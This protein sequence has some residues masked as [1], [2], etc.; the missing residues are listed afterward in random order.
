MTVT[1][2]Q[3]VGNTD[4]SSTVGVTIQIEDMNDNPPIFNQSRYDATLV[5][6]VAVGTDI[7]TV[8]ALDLDTGVNAHIDYSLVGTEDFEIVTQN[9]SSVFEGVIRIKRPLDYDRKEGAFYKFTVVAKD[10]GTPPRS[11]SSSVQVTVT[12]INDEAPE[13]TIP[14]GVEYRVLENAA[15]NHVITQIQATDKDGDVVT[16]SFRSGSQ[17][18]G[19]FEIARQT[20]LIKLTQTI[21]PADDRFM[22]VILARDD[23]SCCGGGTT[24]SSSVTIYVQVNGVNT[25]KPTFTSCSSYSP[26]IAEHSAVGTTVQTVSATDG[27]RGPN[28]VVTYTITTDPAGIFTINSTTGDI[29]VAVNTI[30]REQYPFSQVTVK[31]KDGGIPSLEGWCTFRV[32]IDDINDHAPVF[33]RAK[34]VANITVEHPITSNFVAIRA[35]D[36]DVG[37][38]GIITYSLLS[39]GD[40]KF[41]ILP[42]NGFIYLT[43]LLTQADQNGQ[44]VLT[45]MAKDGGNPAL[46]STCVVEV[47]V[48]PGSTKP[49]TWDRDDYS[50]QTYSIDEGVTYGTPVIENMSCQSNIADTRV[51]FQLDSANT[52]LF[53]IESPPGNGNMV[54]LYARDGLDYL[55][56]PLHEVRIRCVNYGSVVLTTAVN[57]KVQLIDIN[58][59]GP[60]F[61]G[62]INDNG[63]YSAEVQENKPSG[64]IVATIDARD[65]DST[66]PFNEL[67]FSV[68]EGS[69]NFTIETG[70]QP[71]TAIIRTKRPFDRETLNLHFVKVKAEDGA[72]STLPNVRPRHNSAI[73][74][75]EVTITDVNDNPPFFNHTLYNISV[76][77]CYYINEPILPAVSV[78]DPDDSDRG[79]HTYRITSGNGNPETFGVRDGQGNLFL[80]RKL[81]FENGDKSFNLRLEAND[82]NFT[83][84]TEVAVTVLDVNDNIPVF[85]QSQYSF[86]DITENDNNVPRQILT[87]TA[88][89]ADVDRPNEIRYHLE[90]NPAVIDHFTINP[91]SGAVSVTRSLDRDQPNGF[92][93]YQFTVAATDER[94]NPNTGYASVSVRPQDMND[95]APRFITDPLEGSVL[96]HSP[97]ATSVVLVLA[98]DYD[99]GENGTVTYEISNIADGA[100]FLKPDFFTIDRTSGLVQTNTEPDTLDRETQ[101]TYR[102]T[103]I[104]RDQGS[105]PLDTTGTLTI[106]LTDKNDQ[107]PIFQQRIYRT[108]MSEKLESGEV[109]RVVAT[110]A[111]IGENAQISYTLTKDAD[112]VHF[113][114]VDENN[115]GSIRVYTPV[116]YENDQQRRFNLTVTAS[117]KDGQEDVC[118]VEIEVV[119]FNDNTPQ[120]TPSTATTN[121]SEDA[122][123]GK[124]LYTFSASDLDSGINQ[125]FEFSIRRESDPMHQFFIDPTSGEVKTGQTPLDRET[126][127]RHQIII[128]AI[129]KGN[130]PLTGT[131][132]LVVI[133]DDVND[134]YPTFRQDYHPH[135]LEEEDNVN[136][137]VQEILAKDPDAPP[138]GPPFGFSLT[139]CP[140]GTCPCDVKLTCEDTFQ[141]RFNPASDGG[142]GTATISTSSRFNREQQKYYYI[143][144][145][146]WDMRGSDS[147]EAQT[148]TNT[149]TVTI[150]DINDNDM[151]P[152]T[153]DIFVYNYEGMF[154]P[155]AIG[156]V[157]VEDQDDWDLPDKTFTFAGPA[158]MEK[159]FTVDSDTGM[160]TMQKGVPSN[161]AT[162]PYRFTVTVYDKQFDS[163]VTSTVSVVIHDL[164]EEA[165]R[166]SGAVR[167]KDT[168]AEQFIKVPS[169]PSAGST[170]R[171]QYEEL[172]VLLAEKL[173]TDPANVEIIS[174]QDVEGGFTDV[175]YSA[176]GSPYYPPSQ[177]DSLVVLNKAE[178]ESKLGVEIEEVPIDTCAQEVFEGGCYN[179][180]NITGQPAMVNANGTSFVGVEVFIQAMEGCRALQ[181]P[182]PN[183]CSGD[184]CYHGGTCKKDDFGVLSCQCPPDFDGPRCQQLRHSFDGSSYALYASLEQ[185]ED[186]ETSIEFITTQADGLLL[187][188]GPLVAPTGQQPTDFIALELLGGQPRLSIDHGSG[189]AT[190]TLN[191]RDLSNNQVITSLADGKWHKIDIIRKGKFVEM[192]V[193]DCAMVAGSGSE[194]VAPDISPCRVNSTTGGENRFLN[195]ANLL[196][197]GGRSSGFPTSV[198][199][200]GFNGCIKNLVH[201][202]KY[203]DLHYKTTPG[204]PSGQNGCPRED[205]ICGTTCGTNGVCTASFTPQQATC[206]CK[207]G[208]RGSG[209]GTAT[210]VRDLKVSSYLQWTLKS[211]STTPG[212]QLEVQ[213]MYRTWDRDGVLF[214]TSSQGNT[215]SVILELKDGH[216]QAVYNLGDG[217]RMLLLNQTDASNG[218]WHVARFRR[219]MHLA[220]LTLDDGEGR[221][222]ASNRVGLDENIYMTLDTSS[223]LYAGAIVTNPQ[224]A[225][226]IDRDLTDTCVQDV[227]LNKEWMPMKA[228][229]NSQSTIANH[230]NE[231]NVNDGCPDPNGC[232]PPPVPP[233]P[234]GQECVNLWGRHKC[235]CAPGY[236]PDDNSDSCISDCV[237]NPCFQNAACQL[238]NGTVVCDCA[239]FIPWQG[240]FCNIYPTEGDNDPV[241]G[242]AGGTIAAIVVAIVVI[243]LLVL[244]AF[245]LVTWY[246]RKG[247]NDGDKFFVDDDADYDIR[248]NV[249]YYDE[250]GAGEEDQNAFDLAK[251]PNPVGET[252]KPPGDMP[253]RS[254]LPLGRSAVPD[255]RP[256]VGNVL[257]DRMGDADEDPEAPPYDTL[258]A[259]DDEGNGSTAGSL[260]SLGSSSSDTSQD[261]DY[262]NQWGPKFAKLAD[263]YGAGQDPE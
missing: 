81:D 117:D 28:G 170:A 10:R 33:D 59:K 83:A 18:D 126:D 127:A 237:P 140:G 63:R 121:V 166:N 130:P 165:V 98:D 54:T 254:A 149:L 113:T 108:L 111:D 44:F 154:G 122:P 106:T 120:I 116:D 11:A 34:Y 160:V 40:G 152:G 144:I 180:M 50:S 24:L 115:E 82:G 128:Q 137:I 206:V 119:D 167:L 238:D 176:H 204:V 3:R 5:E 231:K 77:E 207:P 179:Y 174:V 141:F 158:W 30:D 8:K 175:R 146:M 76:S 104:L 201:N 148:G 13:F 124:L 262:L 31:G 191:G 90:G 2:T 243:V 232:V 162:N 96:E 39:D 132:T 61:Q 20:G 214:T 48:K 192:M 51:E 183:E 53:Y 251:L 112:R 75:V 189:S 197:V 88:T 203:Y 234:I 169:S 32:T 185:C 41:G 217:Q 47:N 259:F 99:F 155:L 22:L 23:G 100:G 168:S 216:L 178:F 156:R 16:Y 131:A 17:N 211:A 52:D 19:K 226:V 42:A 80:L 129:D 261:Y 161:T 150:A 187:Y 97:K 36:A 258:I 68:T 69:E 110:D 257:H 249:I 145:I 182:E 65:A 134:N 223:P 230:V 1:A 212:S 37:N 114:V 240:Q 87:V 15:V 253:R 27:D 248:E 56:K 159:Y 157:Y 55:A 173:D 12:N 62:L 224:G 136:R 85:S 38:N 7:L 4:F 164:T 221:N 139:T 103:I 196:S 93:I 245:L 57:P 123:R 260:S 138:F 135:V 255:D 91:T 220:T 225:E 133:V 177:T 198:T 252:M 78:S 35:S 239:S 107:P 95:N 163:T 49:P 247:A 79:R 147:R 74:T 64:T 109:I 105:P 235:S 219:V 72:P 228:G 218:Q 205:E 102:V 45:A 151:A 195:V 125:Q 242:I 190:L 84:T 71:N 142:N 202:T 213:L 188:N 215:K 94:T 263:M 21:Q 6:N 46:N 67:T 200:P 26:S 58:N 171:S 29:V 222:H 244:L 89:D 70:Q 236:H 233:C 172:H 66:N 256:D 43:Q 184:Y 181:F 229:E 246:K 14:D 60:E 9:T 210:T 199:A 25:Q 194:G 209:C 86:N 193:D 241:V 118:Y 73:V 250:E 186:S 227:R 143:P 101:D 92:A 153:Q 208:W